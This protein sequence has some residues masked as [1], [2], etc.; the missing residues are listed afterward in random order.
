LRAQGF[1]VT[2][3]VVGLGLN[4]ADRKRIRRLATLGGGSYFDAQGAG[5]LDEALAG[6]VSAP[7][8]VRDS[9]GSVVGRGLVNGRPLELSPGTYRVTVL[10]APP[11]E[12]E[13]VVLGSGDT[14]TLTLPSG[15]STP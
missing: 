10:T 6:A 15:P 13:A 5:Q 12:F 14:A 7:Y 3:N 2:V 1:D 4:K 11:Y 9:G 8:E